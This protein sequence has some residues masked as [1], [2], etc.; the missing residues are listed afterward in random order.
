VEESMFNFLKNVKNLAVMAVSSNFNWLVDNRNLITNVTKIIVLTPPANQRE[1]KRQYRGSD[2]YFKYI[3]EMKEAAEICDCVMFVN[4]AQDFINMYLSH[5]NKYG[6]LKYIIMN[7][8][9]NGSFK[10][11]S[12]V[13]INGCEYDVLDIKEQN[14]IPAVPKS[15]P[16]PV[17]APKE[18]ITKAKEEPIAVAQKEETKEIES[19]TEEKT[20]HKD[21]IIDKKKSFGR[22]KK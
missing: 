7:K 16:I 20:G 1:L 18:I 8:G 19:K 15:I 2:I 22:G 5:A 9:I 17:E 3:D 6:N 14:I 13:N 12:S 10:C 21:A 4:V 11:I